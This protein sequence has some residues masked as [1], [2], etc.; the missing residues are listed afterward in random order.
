[1]IKAKC[2]NCNC[3]I[4][5]PHIEYEE[6]CYLCFLIMGYELDYE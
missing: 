5:I 3:D 6:Y 1:M 2:Q 4:T